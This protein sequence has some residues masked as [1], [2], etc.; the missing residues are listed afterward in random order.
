MALFLVYL[1][2]GLHT[3]KV[4]PIRVGLGKP[5]GET[6]GEQD[7]VVINEV[8]M[9]KFSAVMPDGTNEDEFSV[10]SVI[11]SIVVF[12]VLCLTVILM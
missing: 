6:D 7:E 3:K 4:V 12:I 8:I 2:L 5:K 1:L 9:P 10:Y 11:A